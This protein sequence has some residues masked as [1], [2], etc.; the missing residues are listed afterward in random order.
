MLTR[1]VLGSI[2]A[3][4]LVVVVACSSD[5]GTPAGVSDAGSGS[6]TGAS[7]SGSVNGNGST[8]TGGACD[9]TQAGAGTCS[10]S[11]CIT[12]NANKQNKAGICSAQ[13]SETVPCASG[14]SCVAFPNLGGAFCLKDCT[15]EAS[16]TDGFA[17]ILGDETTG[18][19]FC[20]VELADDGDA[21]TD[22]GGDGGSH[23]D[24]CKTEDCDILTDTSGYC[25]N[26]PAAKRVCDCP[27][28]T[29]PNPSCTA[30]QT[31]A[32]LFC[33]PAP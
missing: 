6:D 2:L 25:D 24:Y 8:P 11:I 30:A 1:F 12:L 33:C 18:A 16:C 22:A 31:G 17:C 19:K 10:G 15:T 27:K 9:G 7:S 23:A 28:G 13:C 4:T 21:G 5:G 3:A 29:A 32:N 20:F 26:N 14:S